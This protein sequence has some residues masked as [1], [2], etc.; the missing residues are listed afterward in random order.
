MFSTTNIL[1]YASLAAKI[2]RR[3][4]SLHGYDFVHE[5]YDEVALA[6]SPEKVQVLRK[7][8]GSASHLLWIDSDACVV[9]FHR[10]VEEFCRLDKDLIMAGH[11]F[12]FDLSGRRMRYSLHGT[13]AG[14]NAGVILINHS[15]WSRDFLDAWWARCV[16]GARRRNAFYEQGQLHQML[17]ENALNIQNHIS[18]VTPASRLNRCDDDGAD[19]C[20]FILHLWGSPSDYRRK[21]FAEIEQGRK[22]RIHVSMPFFDVDTPT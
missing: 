5:Q 16:Q 11:A 17:V 10:K 19:R 4:A 22:P 12:G 20:E 2:N 9:N 15:Q 3:Y 14:L 7:H 6:P 18:L 1:P 13:P 21:V 8:L